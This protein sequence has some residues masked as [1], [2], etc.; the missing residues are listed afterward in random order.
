MWKFLG[1][2]DTG[3]HYYSGSTNTMNLLDQFIVSRG[4]YYGA[5]GLKLNLESVEIFKAPVMASG[6]K[7]RPVAFDKKKMEGYSDHFP[8]QAVVETV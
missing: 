5:Q 6:G 8:I 7:Q 2:P 4:L 3:T 1:Q